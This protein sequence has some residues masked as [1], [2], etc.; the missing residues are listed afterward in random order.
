MQTKYIK[1]SRRENKTEIKIGEGNGKWKTHAAANAK[2][3]RRRGPTLQ[4]MNIIHLAANVKSS[5]VAKEQGEQYA[6]A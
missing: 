1:K 4:I 3:Q 6:K 2:R 5:K